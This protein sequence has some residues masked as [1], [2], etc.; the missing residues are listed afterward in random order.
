MTVTYVVAIS[1]LLG[2]L[3][4]LYQEVRRSPGPKRWGRTPKWVKR[5]RVTL[6]TVPLVIACMGFWGVL[7]EPARLITRQQTIQMN[8]WPKELDGLRVVAISDI[9]AGSPFIDDN[10]LRLIV[11][12]TN[13]LQP[14]LVVILGDYMTG[15]GW[16]RQQVLP[17]VFA[18]ALKDFR[19]PLGAYSVI[20]NHDWWFNGQRV[21]RALEANNMKVLDEEVVELKTRGTSLWLV[22]LADLWT[23]PQHIEQTFS[24]VPEGAP[25]IA[26]AHNPDIFPRLPKRLQLLIAGH[27]HGGQVNLPLIGRPVESSHIG[28]HYAAGLVFE[29][30]HHLFVTTG[31][32]TSIASIRFGVPPEIVLLTLKSP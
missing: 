16:L 8:A 15:D 9:H 2:L 13:E 21:R 14:D 7:I 25:V 27:T 10:K 4:F 5:F 31:I 6:V 24:K 19:A 20:G 32:G 29:N 12:R 3:L 1:V 22:G 23:Q 17:E 28:E 26:I 18:P 30:D 11:E